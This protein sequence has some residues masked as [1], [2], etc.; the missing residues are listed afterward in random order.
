LHWPIEIMKLTFS[1]ADGNRSTYEFYC[2]LFG[3]VCTCT[4]LYVF[5]ISM[6]VSSVFVVI[7]LLAVLE[8]TLNHALLCALSTIYYTVCRYVVYG[9]Q[10]ECVLPVAFVI[11][12][13]WCLISCCQVVIWHNLFV[14]SKISD[15]CTP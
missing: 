5:Q 10:R 8:L 13:C 15:L 2:H 11:V 7:F 6:L 12:R 4:T 9:L 1:P 3:N 14:F